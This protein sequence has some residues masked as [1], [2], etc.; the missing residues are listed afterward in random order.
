MAFLDILFP[1]TLAFGAIGGPMVSNDMVVSGGGQ[2]SVNQNWPTPLWKW[3]ISLLNRT[4][5]EMARLQALWLYVQLNGNIAF[6]FK[7][8]H[9]Y[10][11]RNI[12]C[13][14]LTS[15]T[16][17]IRQ[18]SFFST[19]ANTFLNVRKPKIIDPTRLV[20]LGNVA[21]TDYTINTS[22]GIITTGTAQGTD[23]IVRYTG[24]FHFPV[25]FLQMPW[26]NASRDEPG[27]GS[28][29]SI[30]LMEDRAA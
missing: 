1:D 11:I 8:P 21:T 22:T 10:Q 17:Q 4:K 28:L 26:F 29:S 20:T 15:S 7:D 9:N 16:F 30:T 2:V 23:I 25:R 12:R 3:E 13:L 6:R 19:G 5:A 14:R 24:E 27:F 18:F